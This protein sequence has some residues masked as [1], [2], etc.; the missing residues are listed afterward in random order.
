MWRVRSQISVL[1]APGHHLHRLGLFAVASDRAELVPVG[2]HHVGQGVRVTGVALRTRHPASFPI[3]GHLQRVDRMHLIA[4]R[5]QGLHPRTPVGFDANHHLDR[6]VVLAQ[7]LADQRVQAGDPADALL[8]FRRA[9]PPARLVL[10]LHVVVVL[11]PVVSHEQ[12][13][14]LPLVHSRASCLTA[15]GRPSAS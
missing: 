15:S 11:G 12:H 9:Q 10:Y 1:C 5:D 2:A 3:P 13:V 6:R 14:I 8:E 7:L 4:G